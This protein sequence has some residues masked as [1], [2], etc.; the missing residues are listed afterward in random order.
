MIVN[1]DNNHIFIT[2]E[3]KSPFLKATLRF[4]KVYEPPNVS[5]VGVTPIFHI[6][7]TGMDDT[8]ETI[9]LYK[10]YYSE[11]LIVMST[12]FETVHYINVFEGESIYTLK[13]S[14]LQLEGSG[15]SKIPEKTSLKIYRD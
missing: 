8:E 12:L 1:L 13:P 10:A 11:L 2:N 14:I 9:N 3:N 6:Y 4:E 5:E 7:V 15:T